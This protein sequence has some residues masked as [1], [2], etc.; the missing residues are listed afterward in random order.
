MVQ[1][2][3]SKQPGWGLAIA[4]L[5]V[6]LLVLGCTAATATPLPTQVPTATT[7][8]SAAPS[9]SLQNPSPSEGPCSA[10]PS[11]GHSGASVPPASVSVHV[12]ISG[13]NSPITTDVSETCGVSAL[14]ALQDVATNVDVVQY[15]IGAYVKG[16]NGLEE[17]TDGNGK[18]WQYYVNQKLGPVA[19]DK[20]YIYDANTVLEV[21]YEV[22]APGQWN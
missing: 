19:M 11:S 7:T 17:N 12:V 14:K 13:L 10:Q 2:R 21:K 6:S 4:L 15:P 22:P 16:V 20:F 5:A 3:A 8:S 1:T 18:Y 9:A